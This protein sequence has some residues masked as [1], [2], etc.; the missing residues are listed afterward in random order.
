MDGQLWTLEELNEADRRTFVDVLGGIFEASPWVAEEAW[1]KRPYGTWKE[2][3]QSMA[4]AVAGS[5]EETQLALL[6][7]HPDLGAKIAMTD[8]SRREQAGAGLN[9]LG[10]REFRYMTALNRLYRDKFGFPFIIAVRGK[11][12]EQI[13]AAMRQR[14][15]NAPEEELKQ[16]LRETEEIAR[17]RLKERIRL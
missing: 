9:R 12:K 17:F 6:R 16:A 3:H 5:G 7:A 15:R 2:L 8:E 4:K 11:S 1:K 13:I 14:F 10:S